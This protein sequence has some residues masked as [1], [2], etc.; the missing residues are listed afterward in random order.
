MWTSVNTDLNTAVFLSYLRDIGIT[1]VASYLRKLALP[2][3]VCLPIGACAGATYSGVQ[4]MFVGALLGLVAPAAITWLVITLIH[5]AIYMA[6]FCAAW[7]ALFYVARWIL[8]NV[9]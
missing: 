4:G 1:D 2:I 8:K 3:V 9:F 5:I 7:V 6:V